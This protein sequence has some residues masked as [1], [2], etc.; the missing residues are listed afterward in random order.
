MTDVWSG[1]FITQSPIF[2]PL[3]HIYPLQWQKRQSWPLL[4]DY[5]TLLKNSGQKIIR[6][7]SGFPLQ[8]IPQIMQQNQFE[9]FY[10]P[11][12]YLEGKV[13]T[14]IQNW[15]DFFNMLVWLTF[16]KIKAAINKQ[17]YLALSK[18]WPHNKKRTEI[19]N[20]LAHFDENGVIVISTD[21][22][23]I[24]LLQDHQWKELFWYQ[25]EHVQQHMRCYV[26]GH[27]LYEKALKPYIGMTGSAHLLIM[28]ADFLQ[29][30]LNE[31]IIHLDQRI[32]EKIQNIHL[33]P[34]PVLGIPDW[35]E[36]NNQES[37]YENINYFRPKKV[38]SAV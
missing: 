17:H 3:S 29:L 21:K 22:G 36:D 38:I 25:R 24:E 8:F 26:L 14:R 12:I 35:H 5:N 10:E 9:D 37:F 18:R 28:P 6:T 4:Q 11:K 16:P 27:S 13:Q 2:T 7:Y 31:Q 33:S 23:L 20:K 32:S 34:L 19:E 1:E 15:H 30:S